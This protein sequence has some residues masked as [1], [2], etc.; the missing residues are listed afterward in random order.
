[1]IK[2][3]SF[4]LGS[5]LFSYLICCSVSY[6]DRYACS[7]PIT[8][9]GISSFYRIALDIDQS[10]TVADAYLEIAN[11]T[12][13]QQ[14]PSADGTEPKTVSL[15]IPHQILRDNYS[16]PTTRFQNPQDNKDHARGVAVKTILQTARGKKG[17]PIEPKP[18][19]IEISTQ[20]PA[21][22]HIKAFGPDG[23]E[24]AIRNA[25]GSNM[26]SYS[27]ILNGEAKIQGDQLQIGN[28]RVED[29]QGNSL[30]FPYVTCPSISQ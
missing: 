23:H 9:K 13:T 27:Q 25:Q 18:F 4:L 30:S 16:T 7:I 28:L 14:I 29:R 12:L 26:T 3:R 15:Q 20:S 8:I 11:T 6:A 21:L 2:F 1:M 5:T 17:Q 19:T 22:S 24:L 10:I